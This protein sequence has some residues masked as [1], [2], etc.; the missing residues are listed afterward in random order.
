MHQGG[1]NMSSMLEMEVISAVFAAVR[2]DDTLISRQRIEEEIQ[3][4]PELYPQL[5]TRT[6]IGRRRIIS[7]VMNRTFTIWSKTQAVQPSSFVWQ[8]RS[9]L[10]SHSVTDEVQ[11]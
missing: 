2:P 1:L 5:S 3:A 6:R 8:I 11:P 7:C 4:R 9:K 10:D